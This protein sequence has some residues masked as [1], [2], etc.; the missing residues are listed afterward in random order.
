VTLWVAAP[1][2]MRALAPSPTTIPRSIQEAR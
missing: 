2:V 1:G